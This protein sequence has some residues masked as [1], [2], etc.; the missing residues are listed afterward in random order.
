MI[1][2]FKINFMQKNKEFL[3][4]KIASSVDIY[5]R[6]HLFK[7]LERCLLEQTGGSYQPTEIVLASSSITTSF[8]LVPQSLQR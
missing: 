1:E 5:S 7:G 6:L 3:G 8:D 2:S 4:M